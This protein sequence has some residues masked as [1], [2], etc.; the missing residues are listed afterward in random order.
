MRRSQIGIER[1]PLARVEAAAVLAAAA[2]PP[3]VHADLELGRARAVITRVTQC[4]RVTCDSPVGD[5][6]QVPRVRGDVS[7]LHRLQSQAGH[8]P[9]TCHEVT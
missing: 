2:P 3:R 8:P 5:P 4:Y 1:P 9:A 7:L 6:Q